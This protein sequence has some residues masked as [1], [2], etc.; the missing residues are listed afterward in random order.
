MPALATT[1][2]IPRSRR[3]ASVTVT[4]L[5][6]ILAA[7]GESPNAATPTA[8]ATAERPSPPA[9][10]TLTVGAFSAAAEVFRAKILP[11]FSDQWR[12]T[13]G[14]QVRFVEQY[15][16]SGLLAQ[17]IAT[18]YAADI[19]VFSHAE[20]VAHLVHLGL[21]ADT[22]RSA[23]H[24]GIVSRS[25]VVLAV[26]KDNPRSI[27]D[28]SDLVQP[29]LQIVTPD[30]GTSGGGMWNV[31]AIYGAALRG[32]AGV[33][34]N[35]PAAA[36]AFVA[37]VLANVIDSK[38]SASAAFQCFQ[39]GTGD[40]AI[41]Y[42]SEVAKGWM[43][44][45]DEQRVIPRSTL[46]VENPAVVVI[47][48]ADRH[49]VRAVAEGLLRYLWST[50]AQKRMAFCGLRPIDPAVAADTARQFPVPEDLWTIEDLGGWD[51]AVRDILVP[52]GFGGQAAGPGK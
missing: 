12:R 37:R 38:D 2:V 44:G 4:L 14:Q 11:Q 26:R 33:P 36:L 32:H 30:P 34:A 45:H 27:R 29:G 43:F 8:P 40:V 7:C 13:H 47:R 48:N 39:D 25:L 42:E 51:C 28:W 1:M 6:L 52:A 5:A 10:A 49:G 16:G 21:V 23:P 15:Q 31:C 19:A 9:P 50:E 41:T 22:W 18:D 24:H 46:L 17:A 20:D 35:D 3:L